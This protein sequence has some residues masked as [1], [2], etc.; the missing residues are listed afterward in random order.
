LCWASR[1]DAQRQPTLNMNNPEQKI[2]DI[3]LALAGV[4]QASAQVYDLAKKGST[5]ETAFTTSIHSIFKIDAKSVLDV[6]ENESNLRLGLQQIVG[7]LGNN[8]RENNRNIGSYV[9]GIFILARKLTRKHDMIK[10]LQRRIA[11]A[12][13]QA[14]YFSETHTN[15]IA[16]LADIYV[17][18]IGKLPYRLKVLGQAKYLHQTEIIYKVRALLLAG[19]RSA[20][21]WQQIGGTRWQLLFSRKKIVDEAKK[22]LGRTQ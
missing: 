12:A 2:Y 3:T 22:I 17:N 10:N 8:K 21:L 18:T 1:K 16:S 13:S 9:F 7:F 19:I 5:D 20:I 6:F 14:N 11:Y 4:L 15:V